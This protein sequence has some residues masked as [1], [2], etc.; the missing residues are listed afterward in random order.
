ML[1]GSRSFAL[2][3]E[4]GF[5]FLKSGPA[6]LLGTGR[7]VVGENRMANQYGGLGGGEVLYCLIKFFTDILN[8]LFDNLL[9]KG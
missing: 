1:S 9:I 7:G 6:G 8:M 4:F 5:P 2:R 3:P